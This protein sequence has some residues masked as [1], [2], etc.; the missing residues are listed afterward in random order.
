M[1]SRRNNRRA[2]LIAGRGPLTQVPPAVGALLVLAVFGLGVVLGGLVGA[3]LLGVLL[4]GVLVLLV[5]TWRGLT[6]AERAGRVLVV[7]ILLGVLVSVL[8]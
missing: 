5:G 1:T 6:A 2:P 3:A 8:H 7:V 4:L